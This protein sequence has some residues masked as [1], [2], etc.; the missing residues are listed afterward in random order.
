MV[1]QIVDAAVEAGLVGLHGRGGHMV[2][3]LPA[4]WP[5]F[6]ASLCLGLHLMDMVHAVA[7][8]RRAV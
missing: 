4:I 3:I 8:G 1:R 7:T 2:E 6:D 5:A